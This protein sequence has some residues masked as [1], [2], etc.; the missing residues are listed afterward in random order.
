MTNTALLQYE[1]IR[2]DGDTPPLVNDSGADYVFNAWGYTKNSGDPLKHAGVTNRD[3]LLMNMTDGHQ[4]DIDG[5]YLN[6]DWSIGDYSLHSVTGYR[7]QE[8]RL[9]NTYTGVP[10]PISLFDATRDD[11]RDTFQQEVR[12]VSELDGPFNYVV[13][14]FYQTNDDEFCVLQIVGFL[15][16]FGL[17]TP[18]GFFNNNPQVLCNA[19]DA[20]A[21]A[22][23]AD[24]T[25]DVSDQLH[26]S[27]GV[28]YNNEEKDWTGRPRRLIDLIDD[29]MLNGSLSVDDISEPLDLANFGKYPSGVVKNDKSW[30]DPTYRLNIAYD[31]SDDWFGYVSY[32][33]G[34]RS[35]GY[36]DQLG[37]TLDPI[38]DLAAEPV[39]PETAD[40][41]E[42]GV[43][44]SMLD[45]TVNMALTGYWV[46]YEDAQRTFNV[47]FPNGQQE[48]LFFN[49]AELEVSGLEFEATWR[50]TEALTLRGNAAWMDAQYNDF[51]ADTDFDGVIDTDLSDKE[52]TRS[53]EWMYTVNADYVVDLGSAGDLG[54]NVRMAYEDESIYGYSDVGSQYD[55]TLDAKTLWD[56]SVTYNSPDDKYFV[57][58]VGKNLSDQRYRTGS[59]SVA[60]VWIMSAYGPPRYFGLEFGAKFDL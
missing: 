57:R 14:G 36:N 47:S 49:A 46:T 48:T 22:A 23:Y 35:G 30:S 28:R 16:F 17:G 5:Y 24:G 11:D 42:I 38:T 58:A 12:L 53:P 54:F 26:V 2:D 32:A 50:V 60:T 59:L 20:T 52:P 45:D 44:G 13:G 31:F 29:N 41:Y 8:S 40:S 34:F 1:Y 15:D 21:Y 3:S 51:Q 9:P 6:M 25:Y 7:K 43:R 33:R 56:A 39:D 4:V 10:G 55:T 37:T 18:D 19:Q 27:A